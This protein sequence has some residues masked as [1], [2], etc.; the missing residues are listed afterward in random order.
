M[1]LL[2]RLLIIIFL[3]IVVFSAYNCKSVTAEFYYNDRIEKTNYEKDAEK[4]YFE[5]VPKEYQKTDKDILII[6]SG[7]AFKGKTIIVNNKD[8]IYFDLKPESSGCYGVIMRKV[9]K[10]VKK[11][12]LSVDGRKNTVIPVIENY[13]YIVVGNAYSEKKWGIRYNKILPSFSCM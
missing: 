11:I 8:S 13:E 2:N 4:M 12:K 3:N 1:K 6:F 5:E 10:S 7:A 9:P